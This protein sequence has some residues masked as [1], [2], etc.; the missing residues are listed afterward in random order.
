[1]LGEAG[2]DGGTRGAYLAA[3]CL[4]KVVEELEVLLAAHAVAAGNDDGGVLDVDFRFLDLAVDD[5]DYEVGVVDIFTGVELHDLALVRGVEDFFFHHA[6]AHG[7][8]LGT[9]LGVDDGSHDVAAEGGAYLVEQVG[10]FL[11]GLGILV[12]ADFEGGAV[13]GEAAVEARADTRAE[14]A[15]YAGGTHKAY[16]GLD[17]AEEVDEHCRMGVGGIGVE[18]RVFDLVDHVGAV[19]EYLV[20]DAVELVADNEGFEFDAEAVGKHAALGKELEAHIGYA[21]FVVFAV[22]Y[23]VVVVCHSFTLNDW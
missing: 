19:G 17:F 1:M 14:V 15:A 3:E 23:Q 4:G 12:V 16:L 13:G 22:Y 7:C 6:L 8:H 11:A 21:A 10:V 2:V 5:F 9:A 18:A 20:F